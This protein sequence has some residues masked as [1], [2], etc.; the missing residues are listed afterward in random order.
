[1]EDDTARVSGG[2]PAEGACGHSSKCEKGLFAEEDR[3]GL[4]LG[5]DSMYIVQSGKGSGGLSRISR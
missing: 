5:A 3:R 2:T 1:M 4:F